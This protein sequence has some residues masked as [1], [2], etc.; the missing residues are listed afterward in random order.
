[1]SDE[2]FK[3]KDKEISIDD[4]KKELLNEKDTPS[5][6]LPLCLF[7]QGKLGNPEVIHVKDFAMD[8]VI[9]FSILTEEKVEKAILK[10]LE[11]CIFEDV[12]I[13]DFNEEEIKHI[14]YFIYINYWG[15]KATF[16]YSDYTIDDIESIKEKYPDKYKNIISKIENDT[17]K[18]VIELDIS[19]VEKMNTFP[20]N[21]KGFIK[22]GQKDKWVKFNISRVGYPYIVKKFIDKKYNKEE[23]KFESLY[24]KKEADRSSLEKETLEDFENRKSKDFLHIAMALVLEE[25]SDKKFEKLEEKLQWIKEGNLD[26]STWKAYEQHLKSIE[27]GSNQMYEFICPVTSMPIKRRLRFQL[28]ELISIFERTTD[29]QVSVSYD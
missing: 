10:A 27:F 1:M 13:Y 3:P 24:K 5:K 12:D 9:N 4:V 2:F 11:N 25:T 28:L 26:F 29:N 19:E 6:Y 23:E 17:Y 14:L 15:S 21:F 7:S 22:V 16:Q 20:E 8:D 18:P